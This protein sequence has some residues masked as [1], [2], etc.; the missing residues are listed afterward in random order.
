VYSLSLVGHSLMISSSCTHLSLFK[1]LALP[2]KTLKRI[3]LCLQRSITLFTAEHYPLKHGTFSNFS[4][5]FVVV[6]T[7]S[8]YKN[9]YLFEDWV[10]VVCCNAVDLFMKW[11]QTLATCLAICLSNYDICPSPVSEKQ[12][13]IRRIILSFIKQSINSLMKLKQT[14]EVIAHR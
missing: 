9:R 3:W 4:L 12:I 2:S 8:D 10:T 11:K 5:Y 6:I 13:F 14:F 1:H 7:K